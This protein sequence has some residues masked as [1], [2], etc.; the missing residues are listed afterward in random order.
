MEFRAHFAPN[1]SPPASAQPASPFPPATPPPGAVNP[2]EGRPAY[3]TFFP[4]GGPNLRT[5]NPIAWPPSEF[6]ATNPV[7]P[8]LV[9]MPSPAHR[10]PVVLKLFLRG[11]SVC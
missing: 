6:L 1:G 4:D 8:A 10:V 5:P 3:N 7:P 2:A 9:P 11:L